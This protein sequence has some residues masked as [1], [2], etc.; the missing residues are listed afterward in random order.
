MDRRNFLK[1]SG[2]AAVGLSLAA[3]T[4]KTKVEKPEEVGVTG[5]MAQNVPGISLLG[6]GCMRWPMIEGEDGKSYIDQETV[7]AL[8]DEAITH[9]I[10]Y[11]DT[12]PVYLQGQSERATGLALS[13]YPRE[14]YYVATKLS[15][16]RDLIPTLENGVKMYQTSL[17]NLRTDYIDYYLLHTIGSLEDFNRRFGD[18]GLADYFVKE[19]EAGRVRNLGFSFHGGPKD[20]DDLLALHDKYHWDFIQIQMNYLDWEETDNAKYYYEEITKRNIPVVIME[21]LLGGGL[22]ELP[23]V[24]AKKLKAIEP[25]SSVASWAFRFAGSYPNVLTVLSGMTYMEHLQDNLKTYCNFKPLNEDE[26]ALLADIAKEIATYSLIH[27]TGCNYCMPCPYGID[28]PG[29]FAFYNK[30]VNEGTYVKTTEQKGY[31]RIRRKY[32]AGYDKAVE[33]RRQADHCISCN[34][35][36]KACP[37]HI[38]IPSELK[39]IDEYVEKVKREEL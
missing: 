12:A 16:Q 36:I 14:S 24:L 23:E 7:N 34:R 5:K 27:C 1:L 11:F 8:V 19:R 21:P 2:T 26:K 39:R 10:N 13:K 28:I 6:Y 38:R 20:L 35:C 30:T 31:A 9:G 37:Q 15:N 18:T 3:C 22:S 29:I 25:E 4:P 32:L 17:K 33:T